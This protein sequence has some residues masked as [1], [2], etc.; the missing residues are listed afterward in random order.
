MLLP[1]TL[2]NPIPGSNPSGESLRY[3]PV[4]KRDPTFFYDKIKEARREEEEGDQ[5][6][7]QR[8][9]KKA[10]FAL[11]IKLS[12]EALTE[13]T[14]DLQIAAWLTEA[15]LSKHGFAGLREGLD[16]LRGLVENF[17]E[18]VYPELEEGDAELRAAPVEWVGTRLSEAVRRVPLTDPKPPLTKTGFN[19][20]DYK[21]SRAVPSEQEAQENEA[22]KKTRDEAI[23]EK[24]LTP[25]EF[26]ETLAITKKAFYQEVTGEIDAA[27]ESI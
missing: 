1:D 10:D 9:I 3:I 16:L 22:K 23:E 8:E 26:D 7:W 14:K 13:R 11:V 18:T 2:L 5:G 24:K 15:M 25:E 20:F 27:L 4:S 6:E 17:W 12:T 21:Q 19:W